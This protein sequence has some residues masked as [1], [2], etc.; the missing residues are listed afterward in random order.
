MRPRP[1]LTATPTPAVACEPVL[2]SGAA[3]WPALRPHFVALSPVLKTASY[4]Q[5]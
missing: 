5:I 2:R 1:G 4:L 3:A